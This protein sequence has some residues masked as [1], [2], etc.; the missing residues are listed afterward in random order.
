MEPIPRVVSHINKEGFILFLDFVFEIMKQ[1]SN[2]LQSE[3]DAFVLFPGMGEPWRL[4]YPNE[5][6][7]QGIKAKI[8]LSGRI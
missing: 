2:F 8:S 7:S 6:M 1:Q 5:M 4:S 3:V